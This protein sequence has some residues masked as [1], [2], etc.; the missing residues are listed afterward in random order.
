M[1]RNVMWAYKAFFDK[2]GIRSISEQIGYYERYNNLR[3]EVKN[4]PDAPQ[5]L[6]VNMKPIKMP[7]YLKILKKHL[8][9]KESNT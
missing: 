9:K 2:E 7:K 8:V 5:S 4:N 1:Q 3:D 6:K